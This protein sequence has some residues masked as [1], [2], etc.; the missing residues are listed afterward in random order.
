MD[1]PYIIPSIQFLS[2][3]PREYLCIMHEQLQACVRK[4]RMCYSHTVEFCI[5]VKITILMPSN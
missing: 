5:A 3:Y 4:W 2:V 1:I